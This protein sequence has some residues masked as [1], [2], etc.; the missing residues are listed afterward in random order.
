MDSP[1]INKVNILDNWLPHWL[2][3]K[4]EKSIIFADEYVILIQN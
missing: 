2:G 1:L 4:K 3:Y